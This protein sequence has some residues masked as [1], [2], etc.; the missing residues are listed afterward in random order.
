MLLADAL[1]RSESANVTSSRSAARRR[2][3]V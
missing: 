2:D 1:A 3:H